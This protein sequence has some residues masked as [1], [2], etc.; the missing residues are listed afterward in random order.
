VA[1]L[2]V[3]KTKK[4]GQLVLNLKMSKLWKED[5]RKRSSVEEEARQLISGL[6]GYE[7]WYSCNDKV[8]RACLIGDYLDTSPSG[9]YPYLSIFLSCVKDGVEVQFTM[10]VNAGRY[11][12]WTFNGFTGKLPDLLTDVAPV[13]LRRLMRDGHVESCT[14]GSY[15]STPGFEN[16]AISLFDLTTSLEALNDSDRFHKNT[17]VPTILLSWLIPE[18]IQIVGSFLLVK[19]LFYNWFFRINMSEWNGVSCAAWQEDQDKR[20]RIEH[21]A[22]SSLWRIS[23]STNDPNDSFEGLLHRD[24]WYTVNGQ[25]ERAHLSNY[26]VDSGRSVG[27]QYLYMFLTCLKERVQIMFNMFVDAGKYPD[28]TFN[29]FTGKSP[30]TTGSDGYPAGHPDGRYRSTPGFEQATISPTLLRQ[31]VLAVQDS[32]RFHKN[33]IARTVLE[34]WLLPDLVVIVGLYLLVK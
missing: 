31:N 34:S 24:I 7:M 17:I 21:L 29:G 30:L 4:V 5:Q 10:F 33:T 6:Y 13:S 18:I 12:D 15:P 2:W 3:G 16:A 20:N 26:F 11:P 8:C 22:I 32:D 25:V 23:S 19:K 27:Y 1:L 9:A 28:W 14:D